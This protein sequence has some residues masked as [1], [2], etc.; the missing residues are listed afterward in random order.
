MASKSATGTKRPA[1]QKATKL[2]K[3]Q[4]GGV[5][6]L[7]RPDLEAGRAMVREVIEQNE[8]WLKEMAKR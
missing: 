8:E 7:R 1:R 3:K 5:S 2:A 6:V 4:R